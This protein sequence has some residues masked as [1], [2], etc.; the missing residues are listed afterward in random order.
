MKKESTRATHEF[1]IKLTNNIGTDGSAGRFDIGHWIAG[2]DSSGN[3]GTGMAQV[4]TDS[5]MYNIPLVGGARRTRMETKRSPPPPPPPP[6]HRTGTIA[7]G[8]R[9]HSSCSGNWF[10]N[11][12]GLG[13]T[14]KTW[15]TSLQ[16][17]LPLHV[18]MWPDVDRSRC[19]GT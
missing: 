10:G 15:V 1:I 19:N 9:E 3:R 11:K 2:D 13:E 7:E 5:R 8:G 14:D 17:A 18:L 12:I 4:S 16:S 6:L